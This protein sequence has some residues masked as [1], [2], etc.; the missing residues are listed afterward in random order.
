VFD[1]NIDTKVLRAMITGGID[2]L[3]LPL[4]MLNRPYKM[5]A[6]TEA[7]FDILINALTIKN[8]LNS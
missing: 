6:K 8:G 2:H 1:K 3:T 4:L 5:M 7:F